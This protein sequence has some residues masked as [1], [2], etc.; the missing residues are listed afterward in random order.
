VVSAAIGA[1]IS[2][3][4]CEG[5]KDLNYVLADSHRLLQSAFTAVCLVEVPSCEQFFKV[6]TGEYKF[7]EKE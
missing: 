1:N 7:E 6:S 2:G 5:V 4:F 3:K